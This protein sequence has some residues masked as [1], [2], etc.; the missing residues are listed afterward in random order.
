M[1]VPGRKLETGQLQEH[2]WETLDGSRHPCWGR[3]RLEGS[4]PALP[5]PLP[6]PL[7]RGGGVYPAPGMWVGSHPNLTG[8]TPRDEGRGRGNTVSA[9]LRPENGAPLPKLWAPGRTMD[10]RRTRGGPGVHQERSQVPGGTVG[11]VVCSLQRWGLAWSTELCSQAP[12]T[13][14]GGWRR[15]GRPPFQ[16]AGQGI[17][18]RTHP[19][20]HRP[21]AVPAPILPPREARFPGSTP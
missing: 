16:P 18:P 3:G 7:P 5:G 10:C 2:G 21:G 13:G 6:S 1:K 9:L 4:L 17:P 20:E 14:R 15:R 11:G 12:S 8:H 19:T